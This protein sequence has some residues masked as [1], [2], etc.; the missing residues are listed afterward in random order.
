M[1]VNAIQFNEVAMPDM[2]TYYLHSSELNSKSRANYEKNRFVRI[3]LHLIPTTSSSLGMGRKY[4][5]LEQEGTVYL[6]LPLPHLFVFQSLAVER[7]FIFF[8]GDRCLQKTERVHVS[9]VRTLRNR[10]RRNGLSHD[11]FK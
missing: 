9:H 2:Y 6:C 4:C 3:G 10:S 5:W 11:T 1:G 7:R 8:R